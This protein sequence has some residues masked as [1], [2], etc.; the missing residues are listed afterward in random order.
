M[1]IFGKCSQ[2]NGVILGIVLGRARSWAL[3]IIAASL[4]LRILYGSMT[5]DQQQARSRNWLKGKK[6]IT[7]KESGRIFWF[8]S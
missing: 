6:K 2:T 7:K 4:L 5:L 1:E 8:S 3:M